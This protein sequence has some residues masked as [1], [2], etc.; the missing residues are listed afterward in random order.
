MLVSLTGP[1]DPAWPVLI[2][3][4][5]RVPSTVSGIECPEPSP[6]AMAITI[7]NLG[8]TI[9]GPNGMT[10]STQQAYPSSDL[11]FRRFGVIVRTQWDSGQQ[12]LRNRVLRA[13]FPMVASS[14]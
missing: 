14:G 2:G 12:K 7:A 1:R 11:E 9:R 10:M 6:E 13:D 5:V 4:L 3:R 8:K